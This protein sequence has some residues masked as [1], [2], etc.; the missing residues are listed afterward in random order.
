MR[1]QPSLPVCATLWGHALVCVSHPPASGKTAR[2]EVS[3]HPEQEAHS[4]TARKRQNYWEQG[5]CSLS[6]IYSPP[7]LNVLWPSQLGKG[8]M[9]AHKHTW[10]TAPSYKKHAPAQLAARLGV[11]PAVWELAGSAGSP[12]GWGAVLAQGTACPWQ[13]PPARPRAPACRESC[14]LASWGRAKPFPRQLCLRRRWARSPFALL[15]CVFTLHR[16]FVWL[17]CLF[18]FTSSL[19]N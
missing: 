17:F 19:P 9:E 11:S 4:L 5:E 14:L 3:K 7:V 10:F 12:G 15:I 16:D 18:F 8:V 13:R 6:S 2:R 1:K